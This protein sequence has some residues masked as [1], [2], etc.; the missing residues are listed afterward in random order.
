MQLIQ[1]LGSELSDEY[2]DG[3]LQTATQD[4][5]ACDTVW[6]AT[7]Y[8]YPPK[9]V[10]KQ[11]AQLAAK[12]AE[13][14]RQK[15]VSVELQLSN[16]I[17]HGEYM[18]ARDCSG[19][20]FDGSPVEKMVGHDGVVADYAYCW[21][22][23]FFRQ[24]INETL[25]Y[26]VEL[27][28]PD[29]VW[30]DDDLRPN[31]H[32]PVAF[33]CFCPD[34]MRAFNQ[35]YNANFTRQELV[36]EI[37]HGD[38]QWRRKHIEFTRQGLYDFTYQLGKTIHAACP[39]TGMGYQHGAL[40][41]RIG[42][43]MDFIYD[44]MYQSTGIAPKSRPG[45]GAYDDH[46]PNVFFDKGMW[47]SWQNAMLPAYV[48]CKCP[49]I[50]NLPHVAY[51]K[52]PAGT[53]FETSYY[54]AC[55]NTDM[56][57]SMLMAQNEPWEFY[58]QTFAL[59]AKNRKYWER[60]SKCNKQS[61]QAGL[62]YFTSKHIG[63]KKLTKEQNFFD[64]NTEPVDVLQPF[65]H[66]GIPFAYDQVDDTV[67]L[68]HP[69]MAQYASDKEIETL[70]TKRVITDG[71]TVEMLTKRGFDLG[72][73]ATRI[74]EK[75][76]LL[77]YEDLQPHVS[78]RG[79]LDK[80]KSSFF[81]PGKKAAYSLTAHTQVE[82]LGVY[83]ASVK[84]VTP[85]GI[86]SLIVNTLQGGKWAVL[87]YVPWKGVISHAR[88]EQYLNVADYLCGNTLCARVRTPM[89]N[90]CLPRTDTDG[91]TACVSIT[92]CTVGDCDSMEILIRS[93][94]AENFTFMAQGGV[95]EK[96]SFTKTDDGYL[97]KTP[98]IRAWSVATVFCDE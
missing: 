86:S 21:R 73:T 38:I 69:E 12:T 56:S 49:E 43:G 60:L 32:A 36:E 68:L 76:A 44:A 46:N 85:C 25:A 58:G 47:M 80:W 63:D 1:R 98:A 14:F 33:G 79:G 91:K 37:L 5:G 28:R 2:V 45:G 22:G 16:T 6:I 77:L 10:H 11:A 30:V 51:G 52:S 83:A 42:Y 13:K 57:Y 19:L 62:R 61:R 35:T 89:Q 64:L 70:L 18:S 50:E 78:N 54:F 71:E 93:P 67:T 59:F 7:K 17:G 65:L 92:N 15:G 87:G 40:G 29:C 41:A 74:P 75:Q 94:K 4:A 88:R 72:V 34:C 39:T 90:V 84:M 66:A 81:T 31:H 24:Y 9:E 48:Q 26:Y 8:G 95:E 53:A 82:T 3:Y 27:V 20:L 96:L 23:K 97:V 55:G